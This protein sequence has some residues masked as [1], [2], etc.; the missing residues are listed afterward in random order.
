MRLKRYIIEQ[1]RD[2]AE[3]LK[4][5]KKFCKPYLKEV[6]IKDLLFPMRGMAGVRA[7]FKRHMTRK[8]RISR[9]IPKEMHKA[10]DDLNKKI[11][12]WRVRSEGLF[13]GSA[14]TADIF[15]VTYF[16]AP[17]GKYRYVLLEGK[18]DVN[19]LYRLYD[20][21]GGMPL[22]DAIGFYK[23][24]LKRYDTKGLKQAL[25]SGRSFECIFECDSYYTI[26]NRLYWDMIL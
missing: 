7:D 25:K 8:N 2:P 14:D 10:F 11:F 12:G 1:D 13:T 26:G 3:V 6:G 19:E 17:A 5:L 9:F 16:V 21:L 22:D 15:G 4:V 20:K 24:F 23:V 18:E